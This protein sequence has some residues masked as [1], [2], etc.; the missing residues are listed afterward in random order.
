MNRWVVVLMG[1]VPV[2]S[3]GQL[4]AQ[5]SP[6]PLARAHQ[7]LEGSLNCTKCHGGRK[8]AMDVLCVSCHKDIG[9]LIQQREGLHGAAQ[10]TNLRVVSPRP[11]RGGFRSDQVA[12]WLA[13]PI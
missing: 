11:C 10:G 13:G 8:E 7:E 6:G 12:G 3:F 9:W 1:L 5:I 2:V 4:E